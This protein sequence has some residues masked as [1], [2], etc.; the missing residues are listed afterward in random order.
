MMWRNNYSGFFGKF[1]SPEIFFRTI[2]EKKSDF[3]VPDSR[4]LSPI[5]GLIDL[6]VREKCRRFP[7]EKLEDHHRAPPDLELGTL[8]RSELQ[9]RPPR[10][11]VRRHH[12]LRLGGIR[13]NSP[14]R[15][16][17]HLP[18]VN[19]VGHPAVSLHQLLHEPDIAFLSFLDLGSP[20]SFE[21][22]VAD[23]RRRNHKV[24]L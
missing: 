19:L 3:V 16:A 13:Q 9:H 1:F 20:L 5:L 2:E 24:R 7:R 22:L 14:R 8:A 4:R 21:R 15:L 10:P 17:R 18:A 12:D 11:G 23:D 6:E